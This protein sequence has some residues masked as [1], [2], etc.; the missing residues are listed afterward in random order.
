M[1]LLGMQTVVGNTD[2]QVCGVAQGQTS[3]QS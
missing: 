1:C 3:P 2:S